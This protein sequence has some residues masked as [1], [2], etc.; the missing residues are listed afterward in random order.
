MDGGFND[1]M[2]TGGG[3]IRN[4]SGFWHGGLCFKM[5]CETVLGV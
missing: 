4:V 2:A 3:V 5:G 1:V